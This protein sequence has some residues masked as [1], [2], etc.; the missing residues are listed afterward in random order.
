MFGE[1]HV[2]DITRVIQLAVAPVFLLT[3][4]GS[5][6]AVFSS[7]LARIVDR[8]RALESRLAAASPSEKASMSFER[9]ILEL[10]A[11]V[12]RWAIILAIAAALF[13]CLLIASAF[14][15]FIMRADFSRVVAVLFIGAMAALTGAL[16]FF[17]REVL[18]AIGTLGFPFLPHFGRRREPGGPGA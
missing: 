10:R 12:V 14:L 1:T 3:A 15:G 8:S 9:R 4:M 13:V 18:L 16:A 5:F 6:L 7:R 17:L 2:Q 11:R